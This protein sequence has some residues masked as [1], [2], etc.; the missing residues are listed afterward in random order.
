MD[1]ASVSAV[2]RAVRYVSAK[3]GCESVLLVLPRG[4]DVRQVALRAPNWVVIQLVTARFH[5]DRESETVPS[6]DPARDGR[7]TVQLAWRRQR[8]TDQ[9]DP[10]LS[11]ESCWSGR[12]SN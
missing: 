11:A 8:S 7:A 1:A 9:I 10:G 4:M 2:L 5:L 12:G 6:V 3:A